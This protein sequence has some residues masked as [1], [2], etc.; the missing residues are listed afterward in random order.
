MTANSGPKITKADVTLFF[1]PKNKKNIQEGGTEEIVRPSKQDGGVSEWVCM[2]GVAITY[3]MPYAGT[4]IYYI[5]TTGKHGVQVAESNGPQRGTFTGVAGYRYYGSKAI[6]LFAN[7]NNRAIVPMSLGGKKFGSIANR[8]A[9]GTYYF[10]SPYADLT[11]NVYDNV[12][13]GIAGTP[14]STI[15]VSKNTVGTYVTSTLNGYIMFTSDNDMVVTAA[16]S[17]AD[18][19]IIP[20]VSTQVYRRRN[21]YEKDIENGAPDTTGS[22]YVADTKGAFTVEIADG[23]G[24][25]ASQGLGIEYLSDTYS[26][27]MGLSDYAILAPFPNTR[28]KVYYQSGTKWRTLTRHYMNGSDTNPARVFR[29]GSTGPHKAGNESLD[30]GSAPNLKSGADHYKF[31]SNKPIHICVNDTAA[32]EELLVGWMEKKQV[33]RKLS[34]KRSFRNLFRNRFGGAPLVRKQNYTAAAHDYV[35][36]NGVDDVIE[37]PNPEGSLNLSTGDFTMLC[38]IYPME[39]DTYTHFFTMDTQSMFSLKA[40]SNTY[41]RDIYFYGGNA[42]RSQANTF[43]YWRMRLNRWQQIA[44]VR[45]GNSHNAYYNG[46]LVGTASITAKSLSCDHLYL[47]GSPIANTTEKTKQRR[48]PSFVYA[49]ALSAVEI[50]QNWNAYR[51]RY[52]L[53]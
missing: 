30:H 9:P 26:F 37:I 46:K 48:G 22:Y 25:D 2:A 29:E 18:Q 51:G 6:H 1:D 13:N 21:H 40:G 10:Y 52:G 42:Y 36:L 39:S 33:K 19:L 53:R 20:P 50:K 44:L 24:G 47:G 45:N 32:D 31:V 4:T 23:D 7:G 12:S 41:N 35:E 15:S 16:Q 17:G 34:D 3:S 27:G 43:G 5:D 14:T 8:N 38:W 49:R 11:I 28:V